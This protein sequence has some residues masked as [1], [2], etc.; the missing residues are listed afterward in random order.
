[1]QQLGE[2]AEPVHIFIEGGDGIGKT[3]LAVMH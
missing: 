1:M 2:E 3:C